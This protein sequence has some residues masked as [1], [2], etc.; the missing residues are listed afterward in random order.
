MSQRENKYSAGFEQ[1]RQDSKERFNICHVKER[2]VAEGGVEALFT[3]RKKLSFVCCIDHPIVNQR[4]GVFASFRLFDQVC[5]EV[6]GGHVCAEHGEATGGQ[7]V[8]A[9]NIQDVLPGPGCQ[10]GVQGGPAENIQDMYKKPY[11]FL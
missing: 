2:H 5:G 3:K 8:S 7:P 4:I 1:F 10:Q 9:G 6:E 11:T